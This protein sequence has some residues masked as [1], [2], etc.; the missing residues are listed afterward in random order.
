MQNKDPERPGVREAHLLRKM[1]NP[2]FPPAAR[3]VS[4][5]A[6]AAA[7]LQ[8]GLERDRFMQEFQALIERAVALEPNAPSDEVLAIKEQLDHSY[9]KACA[10]PGD[11]SHIKEAIRKLL[12]VVMRAVRSGIGNDA[13]AARQ[14][15]EEAQA[16]EAH[17]ALQELS[18]VAALT[19]AESPVAEDELV[20]ALLS[21]DD[22]SL[23]RC[24]LLFDDNQLAAICHAAG[25]WLEEI[26]PQRNIPGA[27]R[28]LDL[29]EAYYR[30][31]GPPADAN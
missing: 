13:Y 9:Q 19:H 5:D 24:L 28:R 26:D 30:S 25:R 10:L 27:W 18:L 31:L 1:D 2:L 12:A 22:D 11:Q 8:D 20:P 17:F 23:E 15:D 4:A 16:R 14:L 6:L 3:Q 29:V 7:R 21:E